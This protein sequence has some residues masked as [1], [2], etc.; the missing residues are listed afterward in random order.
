MTILAL[1]AC[2][3]ANGVSILYVT[4]SRQ[5]WQNVWPKLPR[6]EI[7]ITHITNGIHT[8]TWISYEFAGLFQRYIGDDW[9]NEPSDKLCGKELQIFP[10]PNY[11]ETTKEEKKGL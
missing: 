7:P 4:V 6:K 2:G 9:I 3:K 1:K 8:N 5:M 11:G 10:M